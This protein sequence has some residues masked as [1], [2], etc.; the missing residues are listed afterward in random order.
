MNQDKNE[1]TRGLTIWLTGLPSAGKTT[2][3]RIVTERLRNQGEA[4]EMLDGDLIRA[5][6][7]RELGFSRKDREENLRRI[8]F[9]A[10]LL[11]R[12]GINVVIAAISPYRELRHEFRSELTPFVEV[13]V[14]APLAVCEHRDVKGLYERYRSGA[15]TGLTGVDDVYEAPLS[16]EVECRTDLETIDESTDKILAAI[17]RLRQSEVLE[18]HQFLATAAR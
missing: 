8:S 1:S 16:P 3:G 14:N 12:N 11:S 5:K 15:L 7:G 2:L 10:E 6:I 4:V 18:A 17:D 13:F 9:I